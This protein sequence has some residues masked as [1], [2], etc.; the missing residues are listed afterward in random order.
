[1]RV[2]HSSR[3]NAVDQQG[4]WEGGWGHIK[5]TKAKPSI[6][7]S[8]PR[9]GPLHSG[10]Y[11]PDSPSL[12]LPLFQRLERQGGPQRGFHLLLSVLSGA[13]RGARCGPLPLSACAS[14]AVRGSQSVPSRIECTEAK[15]CCHRALPTFQEAATT[16][17]VLADGGSRFQRKRA[18]LLTCHGAGPRGGKERLSTPWT[19]DIMIGADEY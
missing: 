15:S 8:L 14:G 16:A 10:S 4:G 5:S 18:S 17:S 6:T 13:V 12:N 19:Q 7:R 9:H 3:H 2:R 11:L 1:M